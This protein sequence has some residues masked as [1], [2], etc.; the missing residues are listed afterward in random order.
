MTKSTGTSGFI[1]AGS[2]RYHGIPHRR[3]VDHRRDA[4]EILHQH[5]RRPKG[6]LPV[7]SALVEPSGDRLY[8]VHGDGPAVFPAQQILE[9]H[10]E[11]EGQLRDIANSSGARRGKAEIVEVLAADIQDSACLQ[12]VSAELRH[13]SDPPIG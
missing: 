9:Q 11:R 13:V 2:G 3:Q 7:R 8:V 4:G 6:D 1:F 10:L 5:P 12:G